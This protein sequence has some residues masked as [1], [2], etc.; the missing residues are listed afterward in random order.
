MMRLLLFLLFSS[1][2][3][4]CAGSTDA[5]SPSIQATGDTLSLPSAAPP[6]AADA[7]SMPDP[8]YRFDQPDAHFKLKNAL[9]EISGLTLLDESRIGA[10]QDEDG[11]LYIINLET[12]EVEDDFK[13]N[14]DGDYEGVERV[15]D[16]LFVLSSS[17]DL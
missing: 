1:L 17:G 15:G 2:I 11:K 9:R 8:P 16:T 12:G 4:A 5:H 13:F 14:K 3:L 7:P 10:V 6:I